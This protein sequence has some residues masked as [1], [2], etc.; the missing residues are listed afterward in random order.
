[1]HYDYVDIGT[2]DFETSA[3]VAAP[4]QKVLLVE[5]LQF[6]L[7]NIPNKDNIIKANLAVGDKKGTIEVFFVPESTIKQF[8]LPYWMRGCSSVGD[9]HPT[10]LR[11]FNHYQI[12]LNLIE[13]HHIDIVTFNDLCLLYNIDSIN[14]LKIDTEGHEQYILPGVLEM[15]KNGFQ[16]RTLRYENQEALGNKKFID[17]LTNE[18]LK[19]NYR[20]QEINSMDTIITKIT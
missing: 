17:E 14:N 8:N 19:F 15:V 12:P 2:C 13:R 3:E 20:I 18:F 5:P 16:I 4:D 9:Y 11:W 10:V 6:Y 7:D 1:M